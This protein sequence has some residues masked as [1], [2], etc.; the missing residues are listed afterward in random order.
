MLTQI[1]VFQL[2]LLKKKTTDEFYEHYTIHSLN[3]PRKNA[4]ATNLYQMLKIDINPIDQRDLNLDVKCFPVLFPYG[5]DGQYS[6]RLVNLSS[7]EFVKSRLLSMNP[8]FRTNIQ[9]LFFLLHDANIRA[10]KSGIYHKL[11]TIKSKD[12]FTSSECLEMLK[13]DQLEGNLTTIFARLRNTSQYWLGPRSDIETMVTWYG[14][15]TFFLTLSPA[16]Y[17]WDRLDS[18]LRKVNNVTEEGK[19]LSALI[20][21]D[22]IPTS[23]FID[24]EFKA[25]LDFLTSKN[26]PLGV[27]EHYV[28]RRE[29]QTRGLQHFHMLIWIKEAPVLGR[30]RN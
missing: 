24:N 23:R 18:Y 10:L 6:E 20:A 2:C 28:W 26:G 3:E 13:N 27:I 15:V 30:Q 11:S 1:L 12:K 9:Y 16:E 29:Y 19:S 8:I 21:Y 22:P 25:M 4:K 5:K 17:N 14:P 7:S